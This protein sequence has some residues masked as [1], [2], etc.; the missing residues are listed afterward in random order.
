MNCPQKYQNCS[1]QTIFCVVSQPLRSVYL[2]PTLQD[3]SKN[4]SGVLH[5]KTLV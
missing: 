1:N 3:R 4:N 5:A 2:S